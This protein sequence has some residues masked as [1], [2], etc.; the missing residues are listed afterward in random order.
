MFNQCPSIAG[1]YRARNPPKI[2][3]TPQVYQVD[4]SS[5]ADYKQEQARYEHAFAQRAHD[6]CTHWLNKELNKGVQSF[7]VIMCFT[8]RLASVGPTE[9]QDSEKQ[10][11]RNH[12]AFTSSDEDAERQQERDFYRFINGSMVITIRPRQGMTKCDP[13]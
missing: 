7:F 13:A 11:T 3:P 5:Q 2:A 12:A 4:S 1:G 9:S 10:E 8:Y 6:A